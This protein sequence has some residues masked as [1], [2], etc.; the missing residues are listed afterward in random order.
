MDDHPDDQPAAGDRI[1]HESR[2]A[3]HDNDTALRPW[4]RH[5]FWPIA[6]VVALV[7][8][9]VVVLRPA[10]PRAGAEHAHLL[11]LRLTDFDGERF[12]LA[13]YDGRSLV[14]NFW[15]SWCPPCAS[16][17]P[18]LEKVHRAL[19]DR[20]AFVG[21]NL[22]DDRDLARDLASTTGVTYR[23][24]AD[25]GGR[26]YEGFGAP[27]MPA[28]LFIDPHGEVADIVVGQLSRAQLEGHIERSLGITPDGRGSL[29]VPSEEPK[30]LIDPGDIASGGVP[31]DGIP[32]LDDPSF[33]AVEEVGWLSDREPVIALEVDGDA[34][35]YPLQIMTWHEIVNDTVGGVPASIT[36]CPLCNTAYAFVRPAVEG[37][38]TTFGTSGRLYN[39]NLLMY[40]RATESLWVQALGE[41]VVGPLTGAVL[42]RLPAR[43]TSWASF[44]RAFPDGRVLSRA[45]GHDRRYGDNPYPGYDDV[46]NQPFLFTGEVDGRLAAVERVLGVET[47]AEIVAY[48][49]FRLEAAAPAG[50]VAAINDTV[51]GEPA[52][53][54]WEA[55][56]VSALDQAEIARSRDVGAAAAYS[57][58]LGRRVL[59]FVVDRHRIQDVQT[60]SRWD[61]FG[62]ALRGPLRG[63]R[64]APLDH[65]D[66][67]WFDWAAFHPETVVWGERRDERRPGQ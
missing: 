17:M 45:T 13:E 59:R 10:P 24:A 41:A 18:D 3:P 49:Y 38:V 5:R 2:P 42:E 60:S 7:G 34:R 25:P 55:G 63:R 46:G 8:S 14:V 26:M 57:R 47:E 66:S 9:S 30:P 6:A 16:E 35:A 50:R 31:Q 32:P 11:A 62:R 67:F 58:R 43:I 20:V 51:G 65:H 23:L 1:T 56:T 52:L 29:Q 28:T 22:K 33:E 53:V 61:L 19:K 15:A 37:E 36:F 64:L 21:I 27:G 44:A 40:D 12:S 39:S 4:W 48:P 54:V